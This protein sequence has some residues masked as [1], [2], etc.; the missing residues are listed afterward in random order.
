MIKVTRRNTL[1]GSAAA[2][3]VPSI[4]VDTAFAQAAG[5]PVR[6]IILYSDTQG[7]VPQAY[8]AAQLIAQTWRQ[9]GLDVEVRPT[10]RQQL[11]QIVWYERERWD[12]TMWRMVGRP[13]RSDPDELVYNLFHSSTAPQGFNFVGYKNPEYDRLAEQQRQA[14]DP[15]ARKKLIRDVQ[16][17]VS[18]EA[19]YAFLIHPKTVQAFN[20]D[21]W[22][23]N[24]IVVQKGVGIRNFWTFLGATPKGSQKTMIIN[25]GTQL[26]AIHPLYIAGAPDSWTNELIWDRLVRIGPDG[27][28]RPWAAEAFNFA[29]DRTVDVTIR[30]GMTFHDGRPVTV[31]DVIFSFEAPMRTDEVPMF[32][33]FVGDIDKI[34]RT[35]ERTLRFH[36]KRVNSAF[37]TTALGRVFIAPKH[38]WEPHLKS[39]EGKPENIESIQDPQN[40][41][42]GPF[43]QVRARL[44]EEVVLERFAQHWAAPKMDRLVIRIIPNAEAVIGMMRSGELNLLSEYGGDPEVLE[45][46]AN[47]VKAIKITQE[48]DIGMEFLGFNNR[49]PPFSDPVFRAALSAAID[50]NVLVQAAWN[51]FAVPSTSHVSPAL[52]YWYAEDVKMPAIGVAAAKDMLQKAGF[53]LVG[54]RLHYPAGVKETLKPGD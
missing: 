46:L 11:S 35:G 45:G 52:P 50:R 29:N 6:K 17:L 25:S 47:E 40:V 18:R 44:D 15:E 7:A 13:E 41:G 53:T 38:V 51:G 21:L 49:R 2:F 12:A 27:L 26:Q 43:K 19:P 1:L 54:G 30:A 22:D 36:L 39:V 8:Q 48:T 16:A 42:S 9:L 31:D 14:V 5:D 3:T 10:A 20:Q 24:S 32:K 4:W 23:P 34:E 37:A 33:P 28:P